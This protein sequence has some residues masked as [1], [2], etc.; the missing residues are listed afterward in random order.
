MDMI[1]F[2]R[3]KFTYWARHGYYHDATQQAVRKYGHVY[4]TYGLHNKCI[5]INEPTL[6]RNILAKDFHIFADKPIYAGTAK[7]YKSIFLISA[8]ERWRNIRS[9]MSPAFSSGRLNAMMSHISD[10]SD[11]LMDNLE[12]YKKSETF[13]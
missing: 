2:L 11:R 1:S 8:N 13:K 4:G 10:I 3:H 12:K 5:T 9:I 6:I 7:I